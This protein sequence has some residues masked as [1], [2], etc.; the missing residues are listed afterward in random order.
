MALSLARAAVKYQHDRLSPV[1]SPD[2]DPLIQAVDRNE[3]GLVNAVRNSD[4]VCVGV[5]SLSKSASA[6]GHDDDCQRP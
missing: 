5:V 6:T 2:R 1:L 3:F 4:G